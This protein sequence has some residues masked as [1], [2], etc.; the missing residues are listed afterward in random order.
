ML[1]VTLLS[2]PLYTHPQAGGTE[3][4]HTC[5]AK[6]KAQKLSRS[7]AD[8]GARAVVKGLVLAVSKKI[9]I[10][11]TRLSRVACTSAFEAE[12][13][14]GDARCW[15]RGAEESKPVNLV[16]CGSTVEVRE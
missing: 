4:I 12:Q 1:S 10:F 9:T 8:S 14:D 6:M 16:A 3:T 11:R 2:T 15:R 13:L 7:D 5:P